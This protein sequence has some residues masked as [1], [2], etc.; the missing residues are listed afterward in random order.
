MLTCGAHRFP[1]DR[2]LVMGVLNV[3]PDSF[4]DGGRYFAGT[5]ALDHARKMLDDGADI[6]DIGGESTR[7]GAAPTSEREEL[8]RVV[9]LIEKIAA[10][11]VPVSVDTR[12]PAVMQAAIAAGATMI[13]DVCALRAPGALEVVAGHSVAVCLMHMK[14]EPATMQQNVT[15]T[16]V[17]ADVKIF[18]VERAAAAEAAGITRDRIVLDPGFGFGKKVEHNLVLLRRLSEIVALGFPVAVGLSR[19]STIGALTGREVGERVAGSIA[20]ALAAVA[21]GAKIIR[22]H[23]VRE[24]VDALRVWRAV[25]EG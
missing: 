19:K 20:A 1:L 5:A 22:A 6:I 17:V 23:D 15:Y 25:Q 13:N 10:R 8:A 11:G 9:P 2:T 24:T 21:R 7:P 16:D 3:T 4:S 18:L 14:G 12:K